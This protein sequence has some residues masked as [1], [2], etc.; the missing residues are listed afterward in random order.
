MAAVL[1]CRNKYCGNWMR[2]GR[3]VTASLVQDTLDDDDD[4]YNHD[5]DNGNCNINAAFNYFALQKCR[6]THC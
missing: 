1:L 4:N 2:G 3:N 6:Y 5:D